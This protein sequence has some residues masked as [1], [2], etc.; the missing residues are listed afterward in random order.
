MEIHGKVFK[1]DKVHTVTVY[2]IAYLMYMCVLLTLLTDGSLQV[3]VVG[4]IFC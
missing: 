1:I 2:L 3:L 4:M